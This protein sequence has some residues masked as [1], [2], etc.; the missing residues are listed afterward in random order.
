M[1]WLCNLLK[2][3]SYCK[4]LHMKKFSLSVAEPCHQNWQDMTPDQR[5]RFCASCQKTVVD[6]TAM[7]DRE[8]AEFFKTKKGN[9]CGRFHNDQLNREIVV[10]QKHSP[11]ARYLFQATWPAFV[12]FLKS[13]GLKEEV[14]GKAVVKEAKTEETMTMGMTLSEITPIDTVRPQSVP[15]PPKECTATVGKLS[16]E[17]I[18]DEDSYKIERNDSVKVN[19]AEIQEKDTTVVMGDTT[20]VKQTE[21]DSLLNTTVGEVVVVRKKSTPKTQLEPV[22]VHTTTQRTPKLL[23]YPN[24]VQSGQTITVAAPQ[25]MNGMYQIINLSGQIIATARL[26]ITEKENVTLRTQA[27]PA[28]TYFLRLI[29]EASAKTFTEKF[30]VQ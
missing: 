27:W 8:I 9:T 14:V 2:Q 10:P 30:I 4:P 13:C 7:S 20:A 16:I 18:S 21:I 1:L 5:G 6:F 23:L 19:V 22:F 26:T 11:W 29:D 15:L 25:A 24:P 12:F 28:G 3:A 17:G